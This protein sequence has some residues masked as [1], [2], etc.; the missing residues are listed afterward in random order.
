MCGINDVSNMR[1]TKRIRSL[2]GLAWPSNA[3]AGLTT[4]R[5][6]AADGAAA[7][8]VVAKQY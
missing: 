6:K 3:A 7:A 8:N 1:M 5:T 2:K 4:H